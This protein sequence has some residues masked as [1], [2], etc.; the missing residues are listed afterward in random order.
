[1]KSAKLLITF[2]FLVLSFSCYANCGPDCKCGCAQGQPCTCKKPSCGVNCNCGCNQGQPCHCPD[3]K[4]N[5]D[6][7]QNKD[8]TRYHSIPFLGRNWEPLLEDPRPWF[9]TRCTLFV[10]EMEEECCYNGVWLPEDPVLFRQFI[11]DPRQITYSVGWRFNDQVLTKNVVDVSFGDYLPI[12]RWFDIFGGQMQ[13]DIEG[14]LWAVFNPCA[15]SAPLLNADYYVGV[16]ISWARDR[17]SFRLRF[18]HISSH[19]GDE[20]LLLHPGF[21]R[22]NPSAEYIDLFTSYYLTDELRLYGG[23]GYVVSQDS[24][25]KCSKFY[26]EA[27]VELRLPRLGFVSYCDA[28]YGLPFLA[29]DFRYRPDFKHHLDQTYCLGYEMGKLC[30]LCRTLRVFMEYHDGYSVEGQFCMLPTNYFSLRLTY[31]Y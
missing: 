2:L 16:P 6:D 30:G 18:F 19:L 5:S 21:D 27:G 22:R 14:A 13:I 20:F 12:Y 15:D 11:A 28:V 8:P 10:S 7:D 31:G 29:M 23:L 9:D 24:S 4:K 25:F 26:S 3:E 17:L 1:M